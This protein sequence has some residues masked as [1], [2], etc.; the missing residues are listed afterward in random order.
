M[1]TPS[2]LIGFGSV[3]IYGPGGQTVAIADPSGKVTSTT[4]PTA[5]ELKKQEEINKM[6]QEREQRVNRTGKAMEQAAKG[7]LPASAQPNMS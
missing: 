1:S 5:E 4:A 6:S 2:W 3:P 7:I